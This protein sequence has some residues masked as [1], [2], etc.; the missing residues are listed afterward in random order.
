[1][2]QQQVAAATRGTSA[3]GG[4][5]SPAQGQA[6]H[7]PAEKPDVEQMAFEIYHEVMH[8]FDVARKRSGDPFQ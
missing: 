6:K 1:M 5:G 4:G 7:A 2:P 3:G 8:L